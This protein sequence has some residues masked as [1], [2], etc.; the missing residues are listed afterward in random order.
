MHYDRLPQADVS[1]LTQ[2]ADSHQT[3][4]SLGASYIGRLCQSILEY[5]SGYVSDYPD[6]WR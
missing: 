3:A 1:A 4:S 6:V 5:L 2:V